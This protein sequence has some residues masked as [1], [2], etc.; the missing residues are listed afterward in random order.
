MNTVETVQIGLV[1]ADLSQGDTTLHA[2]LFAALVAIVG[3]AMASAGVYLIFG[4]GW[5]LIVGSVPVMVLGLMMLK[6]LKRGG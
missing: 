4:T 2:M 1:E 5:A 3:I 6:G